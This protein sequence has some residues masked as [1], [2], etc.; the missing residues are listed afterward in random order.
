[1]AEQ[2]LR[3]QHGGM[4]SPAGMSPPPAGMYQQRGVGAQRVGA[5]RGTGAMQPAVQPAV[6]PGGYAA[7]PQAEYHRLR[8]AGM[9][10]PQNPG[11]ARQGGLPPQG[12][13][14]QQGG[15]PPYQG[16]PYQGAPYRGAANPMGG[17]SAPGL[18]A[19]FRPQRMGR[20]EPQ[21]YGPMEGGPMGGYM[22]D[23]MGGY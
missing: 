21:L 1:M 5:Q 9:V 8:R 13:Y 10:G 3:E 23:R 17:N 4:P 20:Y 19:Q 22:P 15:Y 7:T 16:V 11:F 18:G 12:R 14:P 2:R 6:Q